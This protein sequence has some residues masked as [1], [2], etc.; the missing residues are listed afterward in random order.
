MEGDNRSLRCHGD[1]QQ[2]M[3]SFRESSGQVKLPPLTSTD[4]FGDDAIACLTVICIG[5]RVMHLLLITSL[6]RLAVESRVI[7]LTH[8]LDTSSGRVESHRS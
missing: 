3:E 5:S 8:R 7:A 4:C 1:L 2:A 6:T